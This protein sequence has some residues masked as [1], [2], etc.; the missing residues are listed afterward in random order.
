M[1]FN[2]ELSECILILYG[3]NKEYID[4]ADI[5]TNV[6]VDNNKLFNQIS[7]EIFEL[8]KSTENWTSYFS[9]IKVN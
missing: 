6:H 9:S 5:L 7:P 4:F 2:R 3:D 8:N 1:D